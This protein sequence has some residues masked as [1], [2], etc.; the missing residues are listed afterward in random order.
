MIFQILH[1]VKDKNSNSL[2]LHIFRLGAPVDYPPSFT[3]ID[4]LSITHVAG[5]YSQYDLM[6]FFELVID[7]QAV[8]DAFSMS[9]KDQMISKDT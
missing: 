5:A 1:L 4:D 7:M 8:Y 2:Q 6:D 3:I 9:L